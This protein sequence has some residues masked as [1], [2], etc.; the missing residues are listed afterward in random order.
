MY[1]GDE[2]HA[3][4]L[5]LLAR[6]ADQLYFLSGVLVVIGH[7]KRTPEPWYEEARKCSEIAKKALDACLVAGLPAESGPVKMDT[8]AAAVAA[9]AKAEGKKK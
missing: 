7:K 8:A 2:K 3:E 5:R 1:S 4:H 6:C 9:A